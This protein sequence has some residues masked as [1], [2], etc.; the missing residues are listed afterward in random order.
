[1]YQKTLLLLFAII[2]ATPASAQIKDI[3]I[4]KAIEKIG[5]VV[6]GKEEEEEVDTAIEE[7]LNEDPD[8]DDEY[9]ETYR[10]SDE[11]NEKGT[12]YDFN[13]LR[14]Q[15]SGKRVACI[16]MDNVRQLNKGFGACAGRGGVRFWIY[17]TEDGR[18]IKKQTHKH[19]L[20]PD[21]LSIEELENLA[22]HQ[23]K[24]TSFGRGTTGSR[25]FYDF[26]IIFVVCATIAYLAKLYF[27]NDRDN[28]ELPI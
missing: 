1:M 6:T 3:I 23:P 24:R 9:D 15:P 5:E 2:L 28:D 27:D 4:E 11:E 10:T 22:A 19:A 20:H 26:A 18:E 8:L 17:E 16:C 14:D 25:G 12:R 21:E 7:D 13:H